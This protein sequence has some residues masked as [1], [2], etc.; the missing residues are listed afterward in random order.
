MISHSKSI[1]RH[2]TSDLCGRACSFYRETGSILKSR[3][4]SYVERLIML[5]QGPRAADDEAPHS[6]CGGVTFHNQRVAR[7]A[8]RSSD[9]LNR[10]GEEPAG[11]SFPSRS[12]SS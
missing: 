1:V 8:R 12:P 4:G 11:A 9:A 2:M 7:N 5:S 6:F 3:G 10:L